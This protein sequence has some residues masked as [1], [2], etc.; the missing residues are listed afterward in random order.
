MRV[1]G[2][3]RASPPT[4]R[5]VRPQ[6]SETEKLQVLF[7][8]AGHAQEFTAELPGWQRGQRGRHGQ[9]G[10]AVPVASEA[11]VPLRERRWLS[12]L[13]V[14]AGQLPCRLSGTRRRWLS[15]SARLVSPFPALLLAQLIPS[16][17][18][19]DFGISCAARSRSPDLCRSGEGKH[20]AVGWRVAFPGSATASGSGVWLLGTPREAGM[21]WVTGRSLHGAA[22]R[23][24]AALFPAE[25][26]SC[27]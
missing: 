27:P 19:V 25:F 2:S 26:H 13:P 3:L 20:G 16:S 11:R 24:P 4:P 23:V 5:R 18:A 8:H 7:L 21:G 10:T 15:P 14:T 17:A 6:N 12:Q 22:Q 1:W 9:G